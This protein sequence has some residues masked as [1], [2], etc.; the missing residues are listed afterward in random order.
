MLPSPCG[1]CSGCLVNRK[2][3]WTHRI[4]LESYAHEKNSFITLTYEDKHLPKTQDGIPTLNKT[5]LQNFFKNLRRRLPDKIRYYAVGEYGTAGERGINPH[6]HACLFNVG[7]EDAQAVQD[8]WREP[9]GRGKQGEI[10][11]FTDT[12]S[13]TP[14]SAA[15]VAGYVQKKTVINKEQWEHLGIQPEYSTMSQGIG[16]NAVK[17]IA[18]TIRKH[19]EIL[20]PAGDVPT[21]L[22]HGERK[23]PLGKYLREKIRWELDMERTETVYMDEFTGELETKVKWHAK[24]LQKQAY[25]QELQDMQKNTQE[26]KKLPDEATVSIKNLLKYQNKQQIENEEKRRKIF[27]K[28]NKV[29]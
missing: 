9:T 11:G 24:E 16:K 17:L 13:L 15:Y 22:L 3:L 7:E 2:Q 26:D 5:H 27:T 21:Y 4:V 1:K 28:N 20:T 14:Q 18:D 19:P 6:F 29:L 10:M 23:L 25:K 8:A 12:G